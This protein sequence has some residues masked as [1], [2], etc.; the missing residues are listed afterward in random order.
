MNDDTVLST[1][2]CMTSSGAWCRLS[3]RPHTVEVEEVPCS[4]L[5]M[6]YFDRLKEYNIVRES[7]HISKCLDDYYEGIQISDELRKVYQIHDF[8]N[9]AF[10]SRYKHQHIDQCCTPPLLRISLWW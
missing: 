9:K 10:L 8:M 4:V 1:I 6:D 5:S 2:E 3:S 7:G